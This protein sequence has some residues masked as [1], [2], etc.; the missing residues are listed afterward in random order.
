MYLA[1]V[2]S[3]EGTQILILFRR[4][5]DAL[6]ISFFEFPG[7]LVRVHRVPFLVLFLVGGGDI[8]SIDDDA[9]EPKLME[10][11]AYPESREADFIGEVIDT[12]G[13]VIFQMPLDPF[14]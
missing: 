9:I 14:R 6:N 11:P 4:D 7:Q 12:S 10:S 13:V 2:E 5:K 8:G 1:A 3:A